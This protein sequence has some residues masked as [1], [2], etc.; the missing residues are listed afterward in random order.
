MFRLY[1]F[2]LLRNAFSDRLAYDLWQQCKRLQPDLR[3]RFPNGNRAYRRISFGEASKIGSLLHHSTWAS[4]LKCEGLLRMIKAVMPDGG[5]CV[6]GGGDFVFDACLEYQKIHSDLPSLHAPFELAFPPPF[7]CANVVVHQISYNNGPMRIIPGTQE[8]AQWARRSRRNL[9]TLWDEPE[10][11]RC[12]VLAPLEPGDIIVRDVRTLHGGTP[13]KTTETRFL[14]SVEF[15]SCQFFRSK[16]YRWDCFQSLPQDAYIELPK[17]AQV[18]CTEIVGPRHTIDIDWRESV[19]NI[20][21]KR[22][23]FA[24]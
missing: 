22:T 7:V 15:A 2:V 23:R 24:V 16:Q 20:M 19:N 13:N 14:P 1:G 18:L 6:S 11:W 17:E 10:N 3:S 9:P 5:Y 4:I 21:N 12:S 8:I